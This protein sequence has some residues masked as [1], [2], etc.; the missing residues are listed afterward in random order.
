MML[1]EFL[2]ETREEVV[3]EREETDDIN[4][5]YDEP[6]KLLTSIRREQRY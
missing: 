2:A 1:N 6:P 5:V 3:Q 4:V